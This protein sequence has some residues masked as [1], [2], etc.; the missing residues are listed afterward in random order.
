MASAVVTALTCAVATSAFAMTATYDSTT[1]N[2]TIAD[3]PTTAAAKTLLVVDT[4]ADGSTL[5]DITEANIKQIDQQADAYTTVK[6]GE[7]TAGT[8]EVRV[9]GDGTIERCTFVVGGGDNPYYN[10]G[11]RLVGDV[12][13]NGAVAVNDSSQMMKNIASGDALDKDTIQCMDINDNGAVAVNDSSELVKY[14]ATGNTD[15]GTIA[16]KENF[17]PIAE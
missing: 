1:G 4:N 5:T 3:C 6:V 11:T 7:L 17:V 2:I 12:N 8:Y 13:N 15:L 10:D 9:G 14:L 16:E